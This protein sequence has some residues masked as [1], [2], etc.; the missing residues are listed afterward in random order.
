MRRLKPGIELLSEQVGDGPPVRR[1]N[2][3]E[4]S[5]R[6]W[7]HRG[8]P[9]KWLQPWG[10]IDRARLD[11]E[12]ATL[13]TVVR[14]DRVSV[15]PGLFYVLDGMRVGGTRRVQVAPHLGF[16]DV[17]LA[18]II[19][20]NALLTVDVTVLSRPGDLPQQPVEP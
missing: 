8:D 15:F 18:G 4:I 7:L 3:Y 11:D 20:A 9:V 14:M 6:L 2:F 12:G 19:P 13:V 17:G 1:R 10:I 16:R 5:L